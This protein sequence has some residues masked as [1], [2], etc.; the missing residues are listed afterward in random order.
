[1]GRTACRPD[2]RAEVPPGTDQ[3]PKYGRSPL[4]IAIAAFA[5]RRRSIVAIRR[6]N[7]VVA[8]DRRKEVV[9]DMFVP[10]IHRMQ[11]RAAF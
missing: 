11:R 1:M 7:S 3:M 10:L 8:G 2:Q 5:I 9:S 4:R 6:P